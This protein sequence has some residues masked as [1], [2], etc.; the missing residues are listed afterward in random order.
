MPYYSTR[1]RKL[2][3]WPFMHSDTQ[4]LYGLQDWTTADW[5]DALDKNEE[6]A[7]QFCAML[8]PDGDWTDKTTLSKDIK[9]KID[10]P[11]NMLNVKSIASFQNNHMNRFHRENKG[12]ARRYPHPSL[13]SNAVFNREFPLGMQESCMHDFV[14]AIENSGMGKISH[15]LNFW[16]TLMVYSSMILCLCAIVGYIGYICAKDNLWTLEATRQYKGDT[17]FTKKLNYRTRERGTFASLINALCFSS[18]VNSTLDKFGQIDPST[19]TVLIGMVLGGVWGFVLDCMFGSDEGFREY[20]WSPMGGVQYAFGSLSTTR[21]AR[22][23]VTIIFDVFF[24]VILFKRMYP[25]L[26]RVSGFSQKGREWIANAFVSSLISLSTYQVYAN[27]TRFEWA[28]P[29]GHED[30]MNQWISGPTMILCTITMNMVFLT[31]ETRTRWG[32]PG[33]ND[34]GTKLAMTTGVFFY[35]ALLQMLGVMDPS[36]EDQTSNTTSPRWTD[37]HMPLKGV[38]YTKSRWSIGALMFGC[39]AVFTLGYTIFVTSRLRRGLQ[40]IMFCAYVSL[41]CAIVWLFAYI[42]LFRYTGEERYQPWRRACDDYDAEE[43]RR[44][45][46]E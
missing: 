11:L 41:T 21:F 8:V 42:P 34:P 39:I 24:T 40:L 32:E 23:I 4:P 43:L 25:V 27:M 31:T 5:K 6:T 26:L 13:L 37:W 46:L 1:L 9:R 45:G 18:T 22:Y 44:Y 28:Y 35:I 17:A 30:V 12:V 14:F 38:C 3:H 16:T 36:G 33:F 29:S 7:R 10:Q 20:M 2:V 19:S 15:E